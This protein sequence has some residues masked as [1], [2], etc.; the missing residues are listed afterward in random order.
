MPA[1]SPTVASWE[2]A[3]RLRERREQVGMDAKAIAQ[4]LGFTRNYWSAVENERAL[5]SDE[6]LTKLVE[7][8]EFEED[9][10]QELL[11]LREVA[12]R[13]GWWAR[14][15]GILSAELQRLFGLEHGAQDIRAYESL[16]IPG[17][18][19]TADYA[20]AILSPAITLPQA[21]VDQWVEARM[22]RQERLGGDDP[23]RVTAVISQAALMQEI[24][25]PAVFRRQLEH[26]AKL[27]DEHPDTINVHVIPFTA[28][29]CVLFSVGTFHLIDFA[30]PRLPTVAWQE[31]VSVQ[32]VVEDP[33][34]VRNLVASFKEARG[35]AL[36]EKDSLRLI[37]QRAKEVG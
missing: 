25:G 20:R 9:E 14:Y 27:I 32:S 35:R 15:S 4:E 1:Q 8:L 33:F 30:S 26:L 31:T 12:K 28:P 36:T 24:G 17:L 11:G 2:L 22:R 3:L 18:L 37:H 10:Q 16:L 7:L 23:L 34:H 21:D 29:A 19:Q 5:L 13:R 6:K